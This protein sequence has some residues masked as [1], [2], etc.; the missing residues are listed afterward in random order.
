M[1]LEGQWRKSGGSG[2]AAF[3]MKPFIVFATAGGRLN[4]GFVEEWV[5]KLSG[6]CNL[7]DT[8]RHPRMSRCLYLSN[9]KHLRGILYIRMSLSQSKMIKNKSCQIVHTVNRD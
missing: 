3:A 7:E 5:E 8:D 4:W 6:C 1:G 2:V 9:S